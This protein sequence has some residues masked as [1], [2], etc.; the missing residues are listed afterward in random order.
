MVARTVYP[1]AP[2]YV[3]STST[4]NGRMPA[5]MEPGP[6]GQDAPITV[7]WDYPPS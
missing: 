6:D 7:W 5:W 4:P 1:L 3:T 2:L